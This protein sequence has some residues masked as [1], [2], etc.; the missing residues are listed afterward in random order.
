MINSS[1]RNLKRMCREDL[2]LIENY[3]KAINDDTQ[4]WVLHHRDEVRYLPSG[5]IVFRSKQELIEN[6][7]YYHCPANELIF[8]TRSEH[9]HLHFSANVEYKKKISIAGLGHKGWNKGLTKETDE[10]VNKTYI[11]RS[12]IRRSKNGPFNSSSPS[13][14]AE[15]G[16]E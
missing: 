5:M 13:G 7:R 12:K 15:K 16:A 3:D 11:T 4:M 8:M 6:D 9:G 10:R 2:S 14:S 1:K